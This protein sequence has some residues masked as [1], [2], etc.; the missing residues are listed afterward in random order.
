M[1]AKYLNRSLRFTEWYERLKDA[2]IFKRERD[3]ADKLRTKEGKPFQQSYFN[4]LKAKPESPNRAPLTEY[5]TSQ[6]REIYP[7][8]DENY[9][10]YGNAPLVSLKK[11]TLFLL[12]KHGVSQEELANS[13]DI[14]TATFSQ[15][16]DADIHIWEKAFTWLNSQ[17]KY[18]LNVNSLLNEVNPEPSERGFKSTQAERYVEVLENLML[19]GFANS[20][21]EASGALSPSTISNIKNGNQNVTLESIVKLVERHAFINVNYIIKGEG[22]WMLSQHQTEQELMVIKNL[23][24]HQV[25]VIIKDAIKEQLSQ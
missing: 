2:K 11:L 3:V 1:P 4:N 13:I 10:L 18:T 24:I 16:E 22:S 21:A 20:L 12:K 25:P 7:F 15:S 5:I 9:F 8:T 19:K 6:L 23:L 14:N 17:Y